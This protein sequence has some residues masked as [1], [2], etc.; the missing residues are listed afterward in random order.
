M[1]AR[2]REWLLTLEGD[3]RGSTKPIFIDG[4][5]PIDGATVHPKS[6]CLHFGTWNRKKKNWATNH[7][8]GNILHKLCN[9]FDG[10]FKC[11]F[12][13]VITSNLITRTERFVS[14]QSSLTTY[15]LCLDNYMLFKQQWL[16]LGTQSKH[17]LATCW[18]SG[19]YPSLI[20]IDGLVVER[21][22]HFKFLGM[23]LKIYP[24]PRPLKQSE[25][26]LW[27]DWGDSVSTHTIE[28]VQVWWRAYWLIASVWFS[29]EQRGDYCK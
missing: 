20:S 11:H 16:S 25:H 8:D 27:Q 3:S 24:W 10:I 19:A 21:V 22:K 1:S 2:P 29:K 13:Q 26:P 9:P 17:W 5:N 12:V 18:E 15:L 14:V 6:E 23:H 28:L 7:C 4:W